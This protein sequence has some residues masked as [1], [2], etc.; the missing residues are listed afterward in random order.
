M[1][2]KWAMQPSEDQFIIGQV[3]EHRLRQKTKRTDLRSVYLHLMEGIDGDEDVSHVRVN[4]IPPVA[5]LKLLCDHVL[6]EN[7]ES[8]KA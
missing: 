4:L 8:H 3:C 6:K 5:T 2:A 1:E 7:H